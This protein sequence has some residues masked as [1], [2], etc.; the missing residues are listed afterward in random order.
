MLGDGEGQ[1]R[2]TGAFLARGINANR[3]VTPRASA[4]AFPCKAPAVRGW[5]VC[6]YHGA[7][8]GAPV[9]LPTACT[10]MVDGH[11]MLKRQGCSFANC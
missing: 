11:G 2:S 9:G 7:G 1:K 5:K 4:E 8:G 6:R 3:A 10:S